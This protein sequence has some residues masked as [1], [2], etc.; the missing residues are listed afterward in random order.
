[1]KFS[2]K[3][4]LNYLN[5]VFPH[6]GNYDM[7]TWCF[8]NKTFKISADIFVLAESDS[9]PDKIAAGSAVV[10]RD[11]ENIA[12]KTRISIGIMTGSWTLPEYRN[13]GFFTKIIEKSLELVHKKNTDAL[14]AFVTETNASSRR[15]VAAGSIAI[16][17][18]YLFF[19][20]ININN[21]VEA[22]GV[23]KIPVDDV[24]MKQLYN[25][26]L[27]YKDNKI[28]FSYNFD[29]FVEQYINRPQNTFI[30]KIAE[31]LCII[32]ENVDTIKVLFAEKKQD[33]SINK[34]VTDLFH[35]GLWAT[36]E[37]NKKL[38]YYTTNGYEKELLL[39][40]N[41]TLLNGYFTI[42]Q[43]NTNKE[44]N[45]IFQLNFEINLGDKM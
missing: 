1:M 26:Y 18:Y 33:E 39:A 10:Y 5:Q 35:L 40:K 43:S 24:I 12:R 28:C 42:L 34:L 21:H 9:E 38:Y 15:L 22:F 30:V 29:S 27:K 8:K 4:Y 13:K 2:R 16:P 20:S 45:D 7:F 3:L 31:R 37:C 25:S 19:E 36:N 41:F 6:W 11:L 23:E 17:A 14:C 32:E 44:L